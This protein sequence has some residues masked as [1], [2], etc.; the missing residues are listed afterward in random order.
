MDV[1]ARL[2]SNGRTTIP[3]PV[4]EALKLKAGD[5]VLFRVLQGEKAILARTPSVLDLA[6]GLSVPPRLRGASW[7][8]IRRRAWASQARG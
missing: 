8:E 2:T 1:S 7:D 3:K 4:R 5:H 6:G